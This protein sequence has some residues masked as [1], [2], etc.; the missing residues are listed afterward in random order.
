MTFRSFALALSVVALGL[1]GCGD[2]TT[3]GQGRGPVDLDSLGSADPFD[4]LAYNSGYSAAQQFLAQYDSTFSYD[5]FAEGFRAG[6]DGDSARIAY[7]LGLRAGLE[8]RADTISN[9]N[10]DVFLAGLR[11]GLDGDESRLSDDQL[12]V[13]YRV[14]QDSLSSRQRRN[15]EASQLASLREQAATDP[16]AAERL[17]A[18]DDNKAAADSFLTAVRQRDGVRS[19]P[20]GVL[21]TVTEPGEGPKPTP[22]SEVSIE[23]VGRFIDGRVFDQSQPGQP[24]SIPVQA[25]VPGFKEALL[26]MRPGEKRTIYLPPNLAYGTLGAPGRPGDEG[27]IPPNSALE[28]D[29]TLVEVVAATPQG[30]GGALVPGS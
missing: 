20:S 18:I 11:E 10:A 1:A 26:D 27:G 19:T 25:V 30:L 4:Q 12:D 28:F 3:V 8:L 9:I 22:Q 17:A 14:V 16:A 6:M 2:S 5:L 13:A 7:A 21:Y 24:V 15:E 29:L 23:Y